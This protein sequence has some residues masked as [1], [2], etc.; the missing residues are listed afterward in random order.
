MKMTWT[1]LMMLIGLMALVL[2]GC[3]RKTA[4]KPELEIEKIELQPYIMLGIPGDCKIR[5]PLATDFNNGR[6]TTTMDWQ[7]VQPI[8]VSRSVTELTIDVL[9][10]GPSKTEK[11]TVELWPRGNESFIDPRPKITKIVKTDKKGVGH[12]KIVT[13]PRAK[14]AKDQLMLE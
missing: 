1:G 8:S 6:A 9:S 14:K 11:I 10:K 3:G 7:S 2:V 5:L 13:N 12:L 4:D